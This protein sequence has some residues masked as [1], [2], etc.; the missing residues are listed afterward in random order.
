[1]VNRVFTNRQFARVLLPNSL[2]S[3]FRCTHRGWSTW[4]WRSILVFRQGARTTMLVIEDGERCLL[5]LILLLIHLHKQFHLI[6]IDPVQ[7]QAPPVRNRTIPV[8]RSLE[9]GNKASSFRNYNIPD[10]D[11]IGSG[12]G[13]SS[14]WAIESGWKWSGKMKAI[15]NNQH[16]EV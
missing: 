15:R 4:G 10:P 7:I 3:G 1:M 16:T 12:D 5:L 14:T 8:L 6:G 11:Q 9:K 2:F 13:W